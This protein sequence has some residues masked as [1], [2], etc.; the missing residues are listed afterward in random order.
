M[1]TFSSEQ[2][3]Q[4]AAIAA[5]S[6]SQQLVNKVELYLHALYVQTQCDVAD[7]GDVRK[8]SVMELLNR[9]TPAIADASK[10]HS[11]LM[12][13]SSISPTYPKPE[14][15]DAK[16][17]CNQLFETEQ[18]RDIPGFNNPKEQLENLFNRS[19]DNP[20]F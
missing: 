11:M 19:P 3:Q 5:V 1:M 18:E 17:M 6:N 20:D 10:I 15:K 2:W 16:Y 9:I 8:V 7:M 4:I 14:M 13:L 12:V